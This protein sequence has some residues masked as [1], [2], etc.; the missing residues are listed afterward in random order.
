MGLSRPCI[1]TYG[2][3]HATLVQCSVNVSYLPISGALIFKILGPN[4]VWRTK[5]QNI[6]ARSST[7]AVRGGYEI[8]TA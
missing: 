3:F 4:I 8:P 5:K 6:V 2:A 7:E 1:T